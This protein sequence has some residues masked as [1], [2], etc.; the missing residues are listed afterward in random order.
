MRS[1]QD[2]VADV[3]NECMVLATAANEL[4]FHLK[5]SWPGD[6]VVRAVAQV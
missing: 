4:R 2:E 3:R 1:L 6:Q 5:S